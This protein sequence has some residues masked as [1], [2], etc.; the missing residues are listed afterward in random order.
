MFAS[1]ALPCPARSRVPQFYSW[2]YHTLPFL[3]WQTNFP[4]ALRL[5]V[6]CG[7]EYGF[8]VF[9]ATPVSSVVLQVSRLECMHREW[10]L[11]TALTCATVDPYCL[12]LRSLDCFG[13]K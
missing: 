9:P 2:Y 3:L 11:T 5:V 12:N 7:V 13:R 6:L 10:Y 4:I 1:A 8:N